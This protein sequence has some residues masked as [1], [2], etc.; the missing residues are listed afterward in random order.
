MINPVSDQQPRIHNNLTIHPLIL[1]TQ[2]H[3]LHISRIWCMKN[4]IDQRHDQKRHFL[5]HSTKNII[6]NRI[7]SQTIL[8][9]VYTI[10]PSIKHF[11]NPVYSFYK[12]FSKKRFRHWSKKKPNKWLDL[13]RYTNHITHPTTT[14]Q[15]TISKFRHHHP[16]SSNAPTLTISLQATGNLTLPNYKR[17]ATRRRS[18]PP[19]KPQGISAFP[20]SHPAQRW[21]LIQL[22]SDHSSPP[23]MTAQCEVCS[24]SPGALEW[25]LVHT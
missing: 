16:T 11:R 22:P 10:I 18:Q 4:I 23:T 24:R 19:F 3:N 1:I 25:A 5:H 14:P 13:I 12:Y 8:L 9:L 17:P 15:K 7:I 2:L 6:K 20:P 21:W